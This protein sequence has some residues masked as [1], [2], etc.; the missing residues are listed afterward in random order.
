MAK[1]KGLGSKRF[2][3]LSIACAVFMIIASLALIS[4][5]VMDVIGINPLIAEGPR[6]Y[7]VQYESEEQILFD[8]KYKRGE[9]VDRI[10]DPKH[11]YDEYF[12]YTFRGW[13]ISGDNMPDTIPNRAYYSFLAVAVYQKK[14]I[15]PLPK[16]KTSS[17][18]LINGGLDGE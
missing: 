1:K 15:K 10:A 12:E 6:M 8:A 4:T 7:W 2:R 18:E 16:T 3:G 17:G 14:Q 9:K 5:L 13:D 11:S